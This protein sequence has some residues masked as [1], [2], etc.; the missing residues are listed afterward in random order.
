MG[1]K[2]YPQ[3]PPKMEYRLT[4]WGQARCPALNTLLKWAEQKEAL[5]PNQETTG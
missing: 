4:E 5:A 2:V 1:S 3:V